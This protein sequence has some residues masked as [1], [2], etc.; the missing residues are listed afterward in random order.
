VGVVVGDVQVRLAQTTVVGA[1]DGKGNVT[2]HGQHAYEEQEHRHL[3]RHRDREAELLPHRIG[4]VVPLDAT[5]F[6]GLVTSRRSVADAEH[7]RRWRAHFC[8]E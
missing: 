4:V 8:G 2:R 7:R 5:H 1:G 3:H 6:Q